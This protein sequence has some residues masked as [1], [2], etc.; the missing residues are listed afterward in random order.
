MVEAWP[1]NFVIWLWIISFKGS[2]ESTGTQSH[3]FGAV[4]CWPPVTRTPHNTVHDKC[5]VNQTP[6]T[7]P[8]SCHPH[9]VSSLWF[10]SRER[11]HFS[12]TP[13]TGVNTYSS[14]LLRYFNFNS[15]TPPERGERWGWFRTQMR[16]TTCYSGGVMESKL[17]AARTGFFLGPWWPAGKWFRENHIDALQTLR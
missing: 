7:R 11:E 1:S 5:G 16:L 12:Q 6:R 10:S 8:H 2:S 17:T 14:A 13:Q 3:Y 9:L 15:P 4:I